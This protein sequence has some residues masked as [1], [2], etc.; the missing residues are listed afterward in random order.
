MGTYRIVALRPVENERFE[1]IV[2]GPGIPRDGVSYWFTSENE[3][4]SF[5][6]DLNLSY[7]EAKRLASWRKQLFSARRSQAG[8]A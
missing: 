1:A 6:E 4:E 2:D 7:I 5:V 3:V 8:I